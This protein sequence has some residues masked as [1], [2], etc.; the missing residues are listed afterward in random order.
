MTQGRSGQR[1]DARPCD[2]VAIASSAGGVTALMRLMAALPDELPVPV[3]VV[4]H[5]D[6]RHETVIAEVLQRRSALRVK[7]AEDGEVIAPGTVYV[8]PPHRHLLVTDSRTLSL[9]G[10]ELVH[11]LRPSADL[12]FES[13]AGV[14]GDRAITCVLTG[15]GS[16]G[17]MGVK[18]V[19]T[20]GGT[21][22]VEDPDTADFPG[23][24]QAAVATG[25]ADFV[26]PLEE[27]T[28]VV[29]GLVG[30]TSS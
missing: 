29:L 24:P 22:I 2:V 23:M 9:S 26:L 27:V 15:T 1:P 19:H 8:A 18:A 5:L 30:V 7:L 4:Q 28:G 13:V 25:V 17:S 6:R 21:V 10:S 16:E 20:R 12:L 3:L 11:F 14:F